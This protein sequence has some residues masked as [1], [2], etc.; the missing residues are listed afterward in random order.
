[1]NSRHI[2][3]VDD[4]VGP[5]LDHLLEEDPGGVVGVYLYGS[6]AASG[7]RP[8]SDIDLLFLTRRSLT[9]TERVALVSLLLG[10]SGWKGHESDF[11]EAADR[12]PLE[13][14]GT[15]VDAVRVL[16]GWPRVRV[17]RGEE[18]RCFF[19]N[20]RSIR[21]SATSRRSRSSS[22]RSSTSSASGGSSIRARS[23]ATHRPSSAS[24]CSSSSWRP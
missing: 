9:S 10:V 23:L 5:V 11:P 17:L 6:G 2:S 1:V 20:C 7:L 22:A 15:V 19:R 8:N 14:T 3:A 12:R 24:R 21:S 18:D 13:L 16:T 4:Q